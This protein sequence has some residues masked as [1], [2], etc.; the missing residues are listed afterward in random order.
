MLVL[1]QRLRLIVLFTLYNQLLARG[2][3]V[4]TERSSNKGNVHDLVGFVRLSHR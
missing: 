1:P 3:S 4:E 2:Y